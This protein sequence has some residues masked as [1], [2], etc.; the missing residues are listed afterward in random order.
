MTPAKLPQPEPEQV[1]HSRTPNHLHRK[2][3]ANPQGYKRRLHHK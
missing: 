1:Y 2:Q 3:T